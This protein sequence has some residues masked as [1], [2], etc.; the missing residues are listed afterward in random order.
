MLLRE[1]R[2]IKMYFDNEEEMDMWKK[3]YIARGYKIINQDYKVIG[4]KN[5][6]CWFK[7]KCENGINE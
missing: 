4:W 7:A 5:I 6:R 3:R 1:I 2:T